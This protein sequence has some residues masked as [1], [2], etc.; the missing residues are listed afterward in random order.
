MSN[1][2]PNTAKMIELA[3]LKTEQCYNKITVTISNMLRD[4]IPIN[5]NTVSINAGVSKRFLYTHEDIKNNIIKLRG[6]CNSNS[7]K[8]SNKKMSDNS[9][10]VIIE[11]QKLKIE[12]LQQEV[13]KLKEE[14]K[15]LYGKLAFFQSKQV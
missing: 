15:I 14:T 13:I 11:R 3:K 8:N 6:Q 5:F 1:S 2:N 4:N 10:D 7:V 12:G 9:K